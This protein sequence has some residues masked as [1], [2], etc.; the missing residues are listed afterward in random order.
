MGVTFTNPG[1]KN[2]GVFLRKKKNALAIGQ[3]VLVH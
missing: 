2:T 1:I 3:S